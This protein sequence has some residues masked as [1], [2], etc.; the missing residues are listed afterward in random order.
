VAAE[1]DRYHA[2]R[3]ILMAKGYGATVTVVWV[4]DSLASVA[5]GPNTETVPEFLTYKLPD[6]STAMASE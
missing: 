5:V 1:G 3:A 4:A 2:L 6:P